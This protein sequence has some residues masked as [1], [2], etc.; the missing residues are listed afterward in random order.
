ME[1]SIR[2]D[3]CKS[4][5]IRDM[6]AS[7]CQYFG[8]HFGPIMVVSNQENSQVRIVVLGGLVIPMLDC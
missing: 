5:I 3:V 6:I 2:G 4:P 1:C 7:Y 8:T